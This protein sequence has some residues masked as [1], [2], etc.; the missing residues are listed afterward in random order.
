M[1]AKK[2]TSKKP[3]N[4]ID[5]ALALGQET[6]EQVFKAGE[7]AV[8]AGQKVIEKLDA[9]KAV[10][11]TRGQLETAGKT[12]FPGQDKFTALGLATFDAYATAF[13]AFSKGTEQL[14]AEVTAFTLKSMETSI[15]N[16]KTA[17]SCKS[18]NEAFDLRNEMT[19]STVD[20]V[21]AES[22]KLAEMSLKT[23]NESWA[24]IQNHARRAFDALGGRGA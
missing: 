8:E 9:E 14:G 18:I 15:E 24:P 16:G 4:Q 1:P 20:T 12:L 6:M 10:E 3:N 7:K 11:I 22:A 17:M 21:V 23:A 5:P 2:S 19:R 13:Q